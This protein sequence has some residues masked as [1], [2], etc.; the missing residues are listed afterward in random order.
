MRA[1]I[2]RAPPV[3]AKGSP[4]AGCVEQLHG[5]VGHAAVIDQPSGESLECRPAFRPL[6][7]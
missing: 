2:V 3:A 1:D 4:V 6:R 5:S 7:R